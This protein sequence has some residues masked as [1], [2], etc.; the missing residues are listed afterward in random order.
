V[1]T[2][3]EAPTP[4]PLTGGVGDTLPPC[5][6]LPEVP[7]SKV[8]EGYAVLL[9]HGFDS[10]Q[11]TA[12]MKLSQAFVT[13]LDK[14]KDAARAEQ[15]EAGDTVGVPF[16]LGAETL[17]MRPD[18]AKGGVRWVLAGADFLLLIRSPKMEWC[19]TV[20]YLAAGLWQYGVEELRHRVTM[21]F[22]AED[23]H[24]FGDQH[25]FD[26]MKLR[27]SRA[28]FA[29]DFHSPAFSAEFTPALAENVVTHSSSKVRQK[30]LAGTFS[31][32]GMGE[33]LTIGSKA[34]LE[35]EVYDKTKEIREASGKD[36]MQTIW[37]PAL[38][39]E[40][41]EGDVWRLE[42]RM[43]KEFL[44]ERDCWHYSDIVKHLPELIAEALYT[45]RLAR[46]KGGDTNRARWPLHPLWTLAYRARGAG[47]MRP[48]GKQITMRRFQMDKQLNK[49]L[50]GTFIAAAVLAHGKAGR[51]E[52]ERMAERAVSYAI[53]DDGRADKAARAKERYRF[54]D[55]AV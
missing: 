43:G 48:L 19:V 49:Q 50:A 36:W 23:S 8:P 31:R 18:G 40:V 33:T 27:V 26:H 6:A 21:A 12:A 20:R 4:H 41:A 51:E 9:A 22:W 37:A 3:I 11:E 28:D 35:V 10:W 34:G 24:A 5:R 47:H 30:M 32:G 52:I 44:R 13:R 46:P 45:R 29:F 17:H 14:A 53:S 1:N 16:Q 54:L 15:A 55:E 39:G 38:E 2:P 7:L 25:V 42:I